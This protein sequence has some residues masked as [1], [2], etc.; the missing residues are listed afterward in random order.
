ML[1]QEFVCDL[2]EDRLPE[3]CDR[4]SA[5]LYI[6]ALSV[7]NGYRVTSVSEEGCTSS[8]KHWCPK[9]P[10]VREPSKELL[11]EL[12]RKPCENT[13]AFIS[14]LPLGR[15]VRRELKDTATHSYLPVCL[16]WCQLSGTW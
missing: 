11:I 3:I 2:A 15:C 8:T 12:E 16:P 9:E 1:S 7:V 6:N 4:C 5:L 13:L 10:V 14:F